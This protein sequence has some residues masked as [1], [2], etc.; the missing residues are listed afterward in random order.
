[1]SN[2]EEKINMEQME[3]EQEQTVQESSSAFHWEDGAWTVIDSYFKQD[4]VMILHHLSSFNYFMT[5]QIPAIV[6]E[7]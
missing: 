7:K 1:M 5:N 2:T 6:R 4:N 3:A